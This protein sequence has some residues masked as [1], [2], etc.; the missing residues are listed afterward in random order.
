MKR[1]INSELEVER[2]PLH[3]L[4][5][6]WADVPFKNCTPMYPVYD[7]EQHF[8]LGR[9][10]GEKDYYNILKR[11]DIIKNDWCK[12]NSIFLIRIPYTHYKNLSI[13]DLLPQTSQ[14]ILS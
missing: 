13:D 11:H 10:W 9:M 2:K 1:I 3:K 12:K 4:S 8:G 6:N 14:F 5:I 7:G